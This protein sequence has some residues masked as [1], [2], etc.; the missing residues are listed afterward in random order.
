MFDRRRR[1]AAGAAAAKF[2][3]LSLPVQAGPGSVLC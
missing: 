2:W 3:V 1:A